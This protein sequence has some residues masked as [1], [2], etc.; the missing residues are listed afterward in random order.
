MI[1]SG[2][3]MRKLNK[4]GSLGNQNQEIQTLFA[5]NVLGDTDLCLYKVDES[6]DEMLT[7]DVD[8]NWSMNRAHGSKKLS[9]IN[10]DKKS[11]MQA[12][13]LLVN[14][15]RDQKIPQQICRS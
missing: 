7:S 3:A 10:R 2:M 8:S 12:N 11:E 4:F 13:V 14:F 5:K 9:R 15:P 1:L 6:M